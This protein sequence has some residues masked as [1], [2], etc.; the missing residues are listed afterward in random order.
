MRHRPNTAMIGLKIRCKY[1]I[2]PNAMTFGHSLDFAQC[3]E[4]NRPTE[5]SS[6]CFA[7]TAEIEGS[8]HVLFS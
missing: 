6:R 5:V 1:N 4:Q 3:F 2:R 8:F 7:A